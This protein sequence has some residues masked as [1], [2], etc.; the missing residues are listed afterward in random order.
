MRRGCCLSDC[1]F[2]HHIVFLVILLNEATAQSG[3]CRRSCAGLSIQY[4]F[5]IDDGCGSLEYRSLLVCSD[6]NTTLELRTPTGI[7]P[8][9]NIS[10]DD[11]HIIIADPSMWSCSAGNKLPQSQRF[12]LDISTK[13]SLSN[14]NNFLY[15]N[16]N[17][18]SVLVKPQL[19]Y[20]ESQPQRCESLCDS[21]NALCQNLPF[22]SKALSGVS[23][24]SYY[25]RTSDSLRLM[26]ENCESYTSIY[27]DISNASGAYNQI[28]AYGIR[29]NYEVPITTHCLNCQ[30]DGDGGGICGYDTQ[31]AS[32]LC[33]CSDQ[34]VT[35]YCSDHN[36]LNH[37]SRARVVAGTVVGVMVGGTIAAGVIIWYLKKMRPKLNRPLR[38]GV[39]NS[40]IG[41]S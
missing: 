3:L 5:G 23:C 33:L 28:P 16:C 11:L 13:F 39:V 34:N 26:L 32:F 18:S 17:E 27:W 41:N 20:C 4:P 29:L 22:C 2:L 21:S 8:V 12:S 37:L 36:H 25:P 15:F 6:R 14:L 38:L 19:S 31:S 10:Y 30:N 24:C 40:V 9:R 35:T 1:R 7:Y